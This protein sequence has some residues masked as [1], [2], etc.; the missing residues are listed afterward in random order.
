[1]GYVKERV[2]YL[3]G[4]VAGMNIDE[5]TNEGKLFKEI[6][7]VLDDIADSLTDI[8]ETQEYLG[9]QVDSIDEDLGALE[10]MLYDDCD[11][12][13]VIAEIE[14]PHC[15]DIIELTEDMLDDEAGSFKCTSCGKDIMVEWDCNCDECSDEGEES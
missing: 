12:D 4:L 13:G 10:S 14:C 8:E 3:K 15:H 7:G 6:I 5:A 1:M 2:A 9:E 11:D